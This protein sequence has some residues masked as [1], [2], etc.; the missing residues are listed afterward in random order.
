MLD[1]L[2]KNSRELI[3]TLDRSLGVVRP[4]VDIGIIEKTEDK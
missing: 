1:I 2:K 4:K 3:A